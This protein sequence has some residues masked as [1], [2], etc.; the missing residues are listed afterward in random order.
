MVLM[1]SPTLAYY[2]NVSIG[3]LVKLTFYGSDGGGIFYMVNTTPDPDY[4][5]DSFCT[6][7]GT[8]ITPNQTYTVSGF[9]GLDS[10]MT[11]YLYW[12]FRNGTLSGV[13]DNETYVYS[14]LYENDLQRLIWD[15]EST[16]E[17]SGNSYDNYYSNRMKAWYD[18]ADAAIGGGWTDHGTR[19][20]NLGAD[21]QTTLV[22]TPIPGVV[23]LLGSG[24]IG[25]VGIRRRRS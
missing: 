3:D 6:D 4:K 7:L 22:A 17:G 16:W 23:W 18:A 10:L 21:V 15:L 5:W 13:Y 1:A 8:H 24:L 9:L 12:N 25:L 20:L 19:Q 11:D 2:D 14:D